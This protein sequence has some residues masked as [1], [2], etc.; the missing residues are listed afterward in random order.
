MPQEYSFD[1]T[2]GFEKQELVNALDQLKREVSTRFDFKGVHVDV[3]LASDQS[4]ITFTTIHEAKIIALIDILENKLIKRNLSLAI[5]DKS[6]LIEPASGGLVKKIIP[7]V[8]RLSTEQAKDISKDLRQNFP[9]AK[10]SIQGETVRI[11][12]KSKDEL[13]DI[14]TYLKKCHSNLPLVFDNYR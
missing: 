5:L 13:Q 8:L 12:S 2:A 4:N 6:A 9:K 11:S 3:N 7:L 14:I 10:A 1:L